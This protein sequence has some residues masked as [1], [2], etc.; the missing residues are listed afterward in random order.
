M[1]A[2]GA[3]LEL[4]EDLDQRERRSFAWIEGGG[5]SHAQQSCRSLPRSVSHKADDVYHIFFF[6]FVFY[7]SSNVHPRLLSNWCFAP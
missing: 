4:S 5:G 3:I 7:V 6:L 1:A 2:G